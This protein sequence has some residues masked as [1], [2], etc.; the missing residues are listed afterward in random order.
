MDCPPSKQVS[1][2][3]SRSGASAGCWAGAGPEAGGFAA[4]PH[5]NQRLWSWTSARAFQMRFAVSKVLSDLKLLS[6]V[7]RLSVVRRWCMII[8]NVFPIAPQ[9]AYPYTHT[10]IPIPTN[11]A[12]VRVRVYTHT[13]N[14]CIIIS[15]DLNNLLSKYLPAD[16]RTPWS[17]PCHCTYTVMIRKL[18]HILT[19]VLLKI[20]YSPARALATQESLFVVCSM[21]FLNLQQVRLRQSKFEEKQRLSWMMRHTRPFFDCSRG[22]SEIWIQFFK[23]SIRLF[24]F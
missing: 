7:E 9:L 22:K 2:P 12:G 24:F 21:N 18:A 15:V 8:Y 1:D 20:I 19:E 11:F 13:W 3:P 23:I 10:H 14:G 6:C 16:N 4:T 17:A 5:Y